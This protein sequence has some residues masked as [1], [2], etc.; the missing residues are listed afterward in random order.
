MPLRSEISPLRVASVRKSQPA[1]YLLTP[2][3]L[4]FPMRRALFPWTIWTERREGLVE[5]LFTPKAHS[6]WK[7]GKRMETITRESRLPPGATTMKYLPKLLKKDL[8]GGALLESLSNFILVLLLNTRNQSTR[9]VNYL[10]RLM[11][12]D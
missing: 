12:K 2:S 8:R 1:V 3:Y 11:T 6:P 4:L 9:I 5:I 10:R 7:R